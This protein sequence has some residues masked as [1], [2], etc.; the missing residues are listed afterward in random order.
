M[1]KTVFSKW[2]TD[3][4]TTLVDDVIINDLATLKMGALKTDVVALAFG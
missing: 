1:G 2:V 4:C 3:G